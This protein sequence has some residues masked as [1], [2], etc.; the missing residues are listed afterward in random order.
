MMFKINIAI[1]FRVLLSF[2]LMVGMF[3]A[4]LSGVRPAFE[5]AEAIFSV[6]SFEGIVRCSTCVFIVFLCSIHICNLLLA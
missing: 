3:L 5:R 1:A 2:G 4:F 6:E